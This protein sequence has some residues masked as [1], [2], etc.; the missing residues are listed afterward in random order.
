M[1]V[2]IY[3]TLLHLATRIVGGLRHVPYKERFLQ[4][5]SNAD[6]SE[7]TSPCPS[8]FSKVKLALTRLTSSSVRSEPGYEGTH[9]DYCKD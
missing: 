4:L 9:T 1:F 2:E 3:S 7:L 8:E 6:A 5:S